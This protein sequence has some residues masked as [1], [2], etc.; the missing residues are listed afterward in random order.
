MAAGG[1]EAPRLNGQRRRRRH[2][3]VKENPDIEDDVLMASA[4]G[5]VKWLQQSLW[6]PKHVYKQSREHV[7]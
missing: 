5:D 1:I 7:S 6:N 2:S 3:L 4:I